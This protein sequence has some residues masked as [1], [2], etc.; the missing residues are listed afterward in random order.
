MK[1]VVGRLGGIVA[2]T[3]AA[4]CSSAPEAEHGTVPTIAPSQIGTEKFTHWGGPAGQAVYGPDP[5]TFAT[6]CYLFHTYTQTWEYV[7][8]TYMLR[9]Y[10]NDGADYLFSDH[11]TL[12][13][14][15]TWLSGTDA[16]TLIPHSN[17]EEGLGCNPNP[18][19]YDCVFDKAAH[20][21]EQSLLPAN[22]G[23][24][25]MVAH[26]F[27]VYEIDYTPPTIV[28]ATILPNYSVGTAQ[29][30]YGGTSHDDQIDQMTTLAGAYASTAGVR[31]KARECVYVMQQ[32]SPGSLQIEYSGHHTQV[33]ESHDPI[34]W[35]D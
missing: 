3:L 14:P 10:D 13:F 8:P 24:S 30:Y 19:G 21:F 6:G 11:F 23:I 1:K 26:Q 4:A 25:G 32:V 9:L 5:S 31:A 20:A 18:S 33:A 17:V 12:P 34:S 7:Q 22:G 28:S 2:V 35:P 29:Y 16:D 15:T 27:L